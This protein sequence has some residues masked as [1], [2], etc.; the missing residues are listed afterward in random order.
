MN[1]KRKE[2]EEEEEWE[3]NTIRVRQIKTIGLQRQ[4]EG[5]CVGFR[6]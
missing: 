1:C 6:K 5:D 3:K 4:Y 2:E